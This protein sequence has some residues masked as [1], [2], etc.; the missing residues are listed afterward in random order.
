MLEVY[1]AC[2]RR[3]RLAR[4]AGRAHEALPGRRYNRQRVVRAQQGGGVQGSC[5]WMAHFREEGPGRF[6]RVCV[7]RAMNKGD[8]KFQIRDL[9]GNC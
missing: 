1:D 9:G 8:C 2:Q 4:Y 3:R 7:K 5:K 6:P